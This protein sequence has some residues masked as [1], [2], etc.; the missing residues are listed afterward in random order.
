MLAAAMAAFLQKHAS[1]EAV[2]FA[3][4]AQAADDAWDAAGF[5]THEPTALWDY[6]PLLPQ[7]AWSFWTADSPALVR[8]PYFKGARKISARTRPP[9]RQR[10]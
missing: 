5:S 2:P 7:G 3:K 10:R 8:N 6:E 4:V 9:Q 1:K